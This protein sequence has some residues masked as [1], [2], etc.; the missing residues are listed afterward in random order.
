MDFKD[1]TI[2]KNNTYITITATLNGNISSG[3]NPFIRL[4]TS[5]PVNGETYTMYYT[6]ENKS[7]ECYDQPSSS[8]TKT[9][10]YHRTKADNTHVAVWKFSTVDSA[11]IGIALYPNNLTTGSTISLTIKNIAMCKGAFSDPPIIDTC[12]DAYYG[13]TNKVFNFADSLRPRHFSYTCSTSHKGHWARLCPLCLGSR[14]NAG[15]IQIIKNYKPY[16]DAALLLE[17]ACNSVHNTDGTNRGFLRI[18]STTSRS[19]S[20]FSVFMSK[21]RIAEV[22]YSGEVYQYLEGMV[23]NNSNINN[24]TT[25]HMIFLDLASVSIEYY[26]NSDTLFNNNGT[27]I[28]F[29]TNLYQIGDNDTVIGSEISVPA[30]NGFI[31]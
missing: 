23:A 26:A 22:R 15:R 25:F 2:I 4:E 11:N 28:E 16:S 1:V 29:S 18:I 20:T 6:I 13:N 19:D 14:H 27:R 21:F 12:I 5:F 30:T 7:G 9:W 17:F 24:Q 8:G 10:L 3:Q 31:S